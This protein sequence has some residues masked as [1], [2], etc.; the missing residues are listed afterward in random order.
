[1][2]RSLGLASAV[3]LRVSALGSPSLKKWSERSG[4]GGS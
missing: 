2:E 4:V 3:W 1:M